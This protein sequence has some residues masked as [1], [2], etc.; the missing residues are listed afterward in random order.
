MYGSLI[1]VASPVSGSLSSK[2]S[3]SKSTWYSKIVKSFSSLA[4]LTPSISSSFFSISVSCVYPG[5][6]SMSL[7]TPVTCFFL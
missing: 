4:F 6:I 1:P 2:P 7:Y 3:R 5:W